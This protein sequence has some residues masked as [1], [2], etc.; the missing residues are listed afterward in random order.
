MLPIITPRRRAPVA[1]LSFAFPVKPHSIHSRSRTQSE[2]RNRPQRHV[3]SN[4]AATMLKMTRP[5]RP[6]GERVIGEAWNMP[7]RLCR[8]LRRDAVPAAGWA[9]G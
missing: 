6:T 2:N 1:S 9:Q 4:P 3:N 5:E 8:F 7:P